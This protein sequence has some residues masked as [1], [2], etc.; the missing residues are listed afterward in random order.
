[1]IIRRSASEKGGG[2][3]VPARCHDAMLGVAHT[4]AL[5]PV[6]SFGT[7]SALW[8]ETDELDQR[9]FHRVFHELEGLVHLDVA[10]LSLAD[11]R[12]VATGDGALPRVELLH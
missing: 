11:R 4:Q 3:R 6:Q 12:G 9:V 10:S 2:G 7:V 1:M 5:R 8:D